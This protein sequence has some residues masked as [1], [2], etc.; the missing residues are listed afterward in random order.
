[1]KLQPGTTVV[2]NGQLID[3]TGKPAVPNA[4]LII[5]DGLITYAGPLLKKLG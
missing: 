1:M 4:T 3:G 2:K 5:Q